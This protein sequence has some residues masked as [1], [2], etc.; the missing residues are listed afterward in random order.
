MRDG[1]RLDLL[2]GVAPLLERLWSR[3]EGTGRRAGGF[4][5][6]QR[7]VGRGSRDEDDVVEKLC[8]DER[9]NIF[10]ADAIILGLA[11]SFDWCLNMQSWTATLQ[12]HRRDTA[13]GSILA[14]ARK[15]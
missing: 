13:T 8:G 10:K 15:K 7:A 12:V 11:V 5:S 1:A 6:E 2:D 4:V 9:E 14:I 3:S